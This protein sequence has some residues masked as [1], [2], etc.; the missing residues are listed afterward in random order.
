VVPDAVI[1]HSAGE[2]AAAHVA[3]AL[4]RR[5][6]L[7]VSFHR[8]RLLHRAS[9]RGRMLAAGI[10]EDHAGELVERYPQRVAIAAVN[11]PEAVTLSGEADP[12]GEIAQQLERDGRFVRFLPTD[13]PYHSPLVA[14]AER[15]LLTSLADLDPQPATTPMVSTVTGTWLDGDDVDAGYW[16]RNIRQGVRFAAG[17]DTLFEAGHHLVCEI[18]P[19]PALTSYL[20]ESFAAHGQDAEVVASLRRDADERRTIREALAR[21]HVRGRTVDWAAVEERGRCVALPTYP[22]QRQRFWLDPPARSALAS[23]PDTGHPLL[24]HQRPSPRPSFDA[25]LDDPRLGFLDEHVVEDTAVFPGAGYVDMALAAACRLA[26]DDLGPD[27]PVAL[28]DVAFHRLLF[29]RPGR[30][31]QLHLEVDGDRVT[32]HGAPPEEPATWTT[33]ATARIGVSSDPPERLDLDG[34]RRRCR[35]HVTN[36]DHGELLARFGFHYGPAFRGLRWADTSDVEALARIAVPE[37]TDL[38]VG[39]HTVHPALLDAAFQALVLAAAPDRQLAGPLFPV[40]IRQ[41]TLHRPP[42]P[43]FWTHVL[44]RT[45][46]P[47]VLEGD[48][49]LA[50]DDG[51][52]ALTFSGFRLEVLDD[53]HDAGDPADRWLYRLGWEPAPPRHDPPSGPA[54]VRRLVETRTALAALPSPGDDPAAADY[55][56]TVAPMLDA[57]A[58]DYVGE[59]L[60]HLG[61]SPDDDADHPAEEVASRLGVVPERLRLFTAILPLARTSATRATAAP[62]TRLE[63]LAARLPAFATETRLLRAGG[64]ALRPILTGEVDPR[65]VLLDDAGLELLAAMYHDSPTCVGYHETVG[66]VVAAVT[67][68]GAAPRVIEIGA[69]TAAASAAVLDRLPSDADYLLT[70]VSPAFSA[71]AVQRLRDDRVRA[72]TLDIE[73]D[74]RQQG[75]AAPAFDVV[76]AANVLHATADLRTALANCRR[77][78]APGGVLVLLELARHSPWLD[79]VFGLLDGWWRFADQ[80][81]RSTSPLL[82]PAAWRRLLTAE[83]FQDAS[84]IEPRDAAPALQTVVAAHAP[85][86]AVVEDGVAASPSH[87]DERAAGQGPWLVLADGSIRD[88]LA[89]RLATHGQRCL[90]V[91]SDPATRTRRWGEVLGAPTAAERP[92]GVVLVAGADEGLDEHVAADD[93]MAAQ[94]SGTHRALVLAQALDRIEGE[95][96]PVWLVTLGAQTVVDGDGSRPPVHAPLWG[97]GR[98]MQNERVTGRCQL[99]DLSAD[100]EDAELDSLVAALVAAPE[101]DGEDELAIR[102]AR[103]FVRRLRRAP[104]GEL[105][106]RDEVEAL[107]PASSPFR[108]ETD[109][110]GELERLNLRRNPFGAPGADEV[111]IRVHASGVNFRDVLQ[112]LGMFPASALEALPDPRVLGIECAGTIT[113]CGA[114]V[115]DLAVGDEVVALAWGAHAS[116]VVARA[117]HVVRKPPQLTFEQAA[118][119]VTASVTAEH[120]LHDVARVAP[121]ERVLIHAAAGGVGL[122]AIQACRRHGAVPFATAGSEPK[123]AFL[124]DL[125]VQ[126]VLDSRSLDFVEAIRVATEGEGVDVVL[127][128]LSGAATEASLELLRPYGRFIELGKRDIY[129]DRRLGLRPFQRN[130]SY[131]AVDLIQ[132]AL[133]RPVEARALMADAIERVATGVEQPPPITH[134]GLAEAA[135]AFRFM[136]Q[137]RHIGKVVLRVEQKQHAVRP[138][139]DRPTIHADG[140]Y[141]VSGGLGGF[142]LATARWLAER[143][144]RHLVLLSRSGIPRGPAEDLD[145]LREHAEVRVERADV[146]DTTALATVLERVRAELP[147]V[148]GVVHTAMVLD[149]DTLARLDADRV[150]AV[151]APKL[152][153]A[154]NLHRL[155]EEDPLELFVL[156]SSMASVFGH[157]VQANYAAANAFLDALAAHRRRLGRPGLA[158]GWGAMDR[159]GYVAR[160]AEVA[161]YVLRGGLEGMQP[162]QAWHTLD[163]LLEH[164]EPHLI[165]ARIDWTALAD[166]NPVMAASSRLRALVGE[167]T[168]VAAPDPAGTRERLLR[169]PTGDRPAALE[170]YVL[171][172]AGRVLG[173]AGAAL[174]PDRPLIDHGFDSLMAVELTSAIRSELR[175]R[176]PVVKVLQGA[177]AREFAAL[178][179]EHLHA[180]EAP[181]EAPAALEVPGEAPAALEV[182]GEA[183]AAT[184]ADE[185]PQ[186]DTDGPGAARRPHHAPAAA[187]DATTA[188]PLSAEQ[189]RFWF[190]EQLDPGNPTAHPPA[191]AR[192]RG[193]LDLGALQAALLDVL[194]RHE[195][196][197][198]RVTVQEDE[199][200]QVAA[201][202]ADV[203]LPVIDLTDRSTGAA[204]GELQR[205]ATEEIRRPF[206]LARG[207]LLRA[208]LFRLAADEHVLLLVVHHLATDAW[209]LN[210]LLRDLAT[211]YEARRVGRAADLDHVAVAYRDHVARQRARLAEVGEGQLGYWRRQLRGLEPHVALPGDDDTARAAPHARGAHAPFRLSGALTRDLEALGRR[212]G[213]TLFMTLMTGFQALLHRWSGAV[214]LPVATAVSTRDDPG[215]QTVVGCCI[216]TVVVRGDLD[217]APTFRELLARLRSTTLEALEHQDVPFDEVVAAVRPPRTSGHQPLFETMLVLHTARQPT[218]RLAGLSLEPYAVESGASI[219]ELSLLLEAGDELVGTIEYNAERFAPATIER[220]GRQLEQLLAAAAAA[221]DTPIDALAIEDP[222]PPATAVGSGTTVDLGAPACL[223]DLV[224]AQGRRTPQAIAVTDGRTTLRYA[225]LLERAEVLAGRLRQAGVRP[226]VVVAVDL[227]RCTAAV[228]APLAV[229]IAGGVYLPLDPRQP[230]ARNTDIAAEAGARVIV[231]TADGHH[232]G[233]G[234]PRRTMVIDAATGKPVDRRGAPDPSA[235]PPATSTTGAAVADLAYVI[236]TSGSTGRPKLVGVTHRSIVNQVWARQHLAPLGPADAVLV[237][238]PPG[239]DPSVWEVFGPLT[240]GARLVLPRPGHPDDPSE[241]VDHVIEEAVTALQVVPSSLQ[242]LLTHGGLDRAKRL[243]HVFCGGEPLAAGLRRRFLDTLDADLHHLYGPAEATIDT[244]VWTCGPD[245]DDRVTPIGRPITNV[246]VSVADTAGRAVPPGTVGELWIGGAGVAAGYLGDPGTD[247]ERFVM[248]PGDPGSRWYRTGDLVR[249]RDDGALEFVG[250]SDDQVK[251]RGVRTEPGEIETVLASHPAVEAA[252]VVPVADDDG[253]PSLIAFVVSR[254]DLPGLD[255]QLHGLLRSRLPETAIPALI[256]PADRLPVLPSGK[257]DRRSLRHEARSLLRAPRDT[258][259]PRNDTERALLGAWRALFD[260]ATIGI[261][262]DFFALGGHSLLAVRLAA[263][264]ERDLGLRIEVSDLLERRTVAAVAALLRSGD[265]DRRERGPVTV[266]RAGRAGPPLFLLPGVDGSGWAYAELADALDGDRPVVALTTDGAEADLQDGDLT[267]VARTAAAAISERSTDR[268]VHLAGWS[269]G[270]VTALA[271]A[272]QLAEHG[273]ALAPLLLLDPPPLSPRFGSAPH[274][275]GPRLDDLVRAT[276]ELAEGEV[277][278][279]RPRLTTLVRNLRAMRDHEPEPVEAAAVLFVARDGTSTREEVSSTWELYCRGGVEVVGVPGDHHTM[280]RAPHVAE[281]GAQLHRH[282]AGRS[283]TSPATPG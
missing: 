17:V 5:D 171:D 39:P 4:D 92:A 274:G 253:T 7:R 104:V 71:A 243:R 190:L 105:T 161:R 28:D 90:D 252:A 53:G 38:R 18:S 224:L 225:E 242:V 159:V 281:L 162:A 20:L 75:M 57:I 13:V 259:P 198:T 2:M 128:S 260:A 32:I 114:D 140:T 156:Y 202:E 206:D 123:R 19:H 8:G 100:P 62:E 15:E 16:W 152:A 283:S 79:L 164:D 180:T 107:E 258:V 178:V 40:A 27:H 83:G 36:E 89:E 278:R 215:T 96:P 222:A 147:P 10:S 3:G 112:A 12:L 14:D 31:H 192:L 74:P 249:Q 54:R 132:L 6:A 116:Q 91:G 261:D 191:A 194:Q 166:T 280:L 251:I 240:T 179:H 115:T 277:E 130:L 37:A 189:R 1:G 235:T 68:T 106:V 44:V 187:A 145:E 183:P 210:V 146:A 175:I 94:R 134:F 78:L 85:D 273:V 86:Q 229:L 257:L 148:R 197:R 208:R 43:S 88:R 47:D 151:L 93:L 204:D 163:T 23:G 219:A 135:D 113:A 158:V 49:V 73:R 149:D 227:E 186:G 248:D 275:Q 200:V 137:A 58:A 48:L 121:G 150:D 193:P 182:P 97:F 157:P 131:T 51:N 9:G 244:T 270:A 24:G 211:C 143:G 216:N 60:S 230:A 59:A 129:D 95:R 82:E 101:D 267:E 127:N 72:G 56:D 108:L 52:L 255:D 233:A 125:G 181:G 41:V 61:W 172:L 66:S 64:N 207:P 241:L 80:E 30:A 11:S 256:R 238:T 65:E 21:L 195:V 22:W 266:L 169:L 45:S 217:G 63:E 205:L 209:S 237:H 239:F 139:R 269:M 133:D 118:S 279:L 263:R 109:A 103:R 203:E 176:L 201:V 173:S 119:I 111:A 188:L 276:S 153:G 50:D 117:E 231:T 34:L 245:D 126:H 185:R 184:E 236:A 226:G 144:A 265:G 174:D 69:G 262:D 268:P 221:P 199:P 55:L 220:F 168:T 42:G 124:R 142:G 84:V 70:D 102:G 35:G 167:A 250:R 26:A 228:V 223:H 110:P 264:I 99:V 282:L 177:T 154:W 87:P 138:Q 122:A 160:N 254:D 247:S 234:S 77:L 81:L 271:V 98:V 136:A 33:H 155:T 212:D 25:H 165:A 120:A 272:R 170:A 214:D 246:L 196:L 29:L 67:D 46:D 141:L 213:A 232:R 218:V 76:V